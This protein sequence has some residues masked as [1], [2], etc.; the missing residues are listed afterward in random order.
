M[1]A[2]ME[3]S[4]KRSVQRLAGLLRADGVLRAECRDTEGG[5]RLSVE[6]VHDGLNRAPADVRGGGATRSP[7]GSMDGSGG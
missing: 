7:G 6:L 5:P 3:K 1:L 4:P 2:R